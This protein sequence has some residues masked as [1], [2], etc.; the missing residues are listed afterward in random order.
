VPRS[1]VGA[2][3]VLTFLAGAVF[4]R[5]ASALFIPIVVAVLAS[6]ALE[7]I[8]RRLNAI[9]IPRVIGAGLL[10][11]GLVASAA[12][13]LYGIRADISDA[14]TAMPRAMRRLG[15]WMG[16]GTV[17]REAERTVRSAETIQLAAGWVAAA[18]GQM[19]IVVFLTYFLLIAG[20]HFKRRL[21]ELAGPRLE[22]QRITIKVL[23]DISDQIQRF[24]LVQ[25]FTASVVA[26]ATWIVLSWVGLEQAAVWSILAGVFNSIPYFGPVIVSGGLFGVAFLQFGQ[27]L[28]ALQISMLALAIT[29]LEGWVLLP[30]LLGRAE[31]MHVVV[32]FIGVLVWTWIWG[33]WGTVL[34][35]P[36]MAA[37]KSISDHVEPLRPVS[38]LLAE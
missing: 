24:L 4:L 9:G 16:A 11:A 32:V 27:P 34:A 21:V 30:L 38:R 25:V 18:A 19:T 23:D 17:A 5:T 35:V 37:I 13:L 10:L 28:I 22:R 29:S 33:P 12:A 2:L 7:P 3:W 26:V 1:A 20:Q 6:Y 14:A 15:E 8:V 31:R 36:L